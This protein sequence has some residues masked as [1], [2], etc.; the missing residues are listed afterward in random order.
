MT[1][2]GCDR[3]SRVSASY[4]PSEITRANNLVYPVDQRFV[5]AEIESDYGADRCLYVWVTVHRYHLIRVRLRAFSLVSRPP[6]ISLTP[7]VSGT[8]SPTPSAGGVATAP[9]TS[10][11]RVSF[12]YVC[13]VTSD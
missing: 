6:H 11:T 2:V 8:P 10:N 12:L 4:P 5:R 3:P 9:S 13:Q 7:A 1:G